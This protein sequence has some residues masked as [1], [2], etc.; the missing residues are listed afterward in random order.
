M[1]KI[2]LFR[3]ETKSAQEL[4]EEAVQVVKKGASGLARLVDLVAHGVDVNMPLEQETQRPNSQLTGNYLSLLHVAASVPDNCLIIEYLIKNNAEVN[5]LDA[6]GATPLDWAAKS[7]PAKEKSREFKLLQLRGGT[8]T[9]T[10]TNTNENTSVPSTPRAVNINPNVEV[11]ELPPMSSTV[12]P[13]LNDKPPTNLPPMVARKTTVSQP[14]I[15]KTASFPAPPTSA[16]LSPRPPTQVNGSGPASVNVGSSGTTPPPSPKGPQSIQVNLNRSMPSN[17]VI[18][19]VSSPRTPPP[20]PPPP[21]PRDQSGQ[22]KTGAPSSP[23]DQPGP[24]PPTSPRKGSLAASMPPNPR[25]PSGIVA[26]QGA[27]SPNGSANGPAAPVSTPPIAIRGG[28]AKSGFQN[29]D[30]VGSK[31]SSPLSL[32]LEKISAT[33]AKQPGVGSPTSLGFRP[34]PPRTPPPSGKFRAPFADGLHYR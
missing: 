13:V 24:S 22:P 12:G 4:N 7:Q 3:K 25:P 27:D 32:S 19:T 14:G 16:Q 31:S 8:L 11:T 30:A 5:R 23:R 1:L 29:S 6:N 26:Q 33:P 34:A 10:T 17:P 2:L 18:R 20:V 21:S 9:S 28:L 15:V